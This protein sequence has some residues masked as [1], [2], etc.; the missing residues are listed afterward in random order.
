M[1]PTLLAAN[2]SFSESWLK[3]DTSTP[4]GLIQKFQVYHGNIKALWSK[5]L[6]VQTRFCQELGDT[7]E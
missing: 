7:L 5:Q 6:D 3:S 4:E 2:C 1:Q